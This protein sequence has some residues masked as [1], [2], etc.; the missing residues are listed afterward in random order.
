MAVCTIQN[1]MLGH[2][3]DMCTWSINLHYNYIDILDVEIVSIEMTVT[4]RKE[5]KPC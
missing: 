1:I 3:M 2:Y 4:E 5:Y